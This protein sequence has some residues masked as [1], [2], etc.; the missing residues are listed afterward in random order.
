MSLCCWTTVIFHLCTNELYQC[1]RSEGLIEV[2]SGG[3]PKL[4]LGTTSYNQV[5]RIS[6]CLQIDIGRLD[7]DLQQKTHFH[8]GTPHSPARKRSKLVLAELEADE[9]RHV[10]QAVHACWHCLN[11][12][13]TK[14]HTKNE[15]RAGSTFSREGFCLSHLVDDV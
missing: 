6:V 1:L 2:S 13:A 15:I 10:P 14:E 11:L 5:N 3:T 4:G 7:I 9:S 8:H 12:T